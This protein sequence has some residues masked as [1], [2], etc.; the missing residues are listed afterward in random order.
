M[1]IDGRSGVGKSTFAKRLGEKV[2]GVISVE[3]KGNLLRISTDS[4]LRAEIAK[5]VVQS[6]I[7][8]VQMK[9]Q[10]FSLDDTYMKYFR[11]D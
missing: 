6:N 11:E 5:V 10:E 1:A 8:L 2:K 3:A 7:P 9:V 4:D